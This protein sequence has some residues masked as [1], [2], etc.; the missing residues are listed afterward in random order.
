MQMIVTLFEAL[1]QEDPEIEFA[2]TGYGNSGK[3]PDWITDL[4]IDRHDTETER[5]WMRLYARCHLAM[6]IHGSHMILPCAHAMGAI[7][8]VLPSYWETSI[9]IWEWVNRHSAQQALIRYL[10][11]PVSP[12]LSEIISITFIQLRKL[13]Q[14]A[15]YDYLGRLP[16][17]AQ[18][19]EFHLRHHKIFKGGYWLELKDR[20]G[21]LM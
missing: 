12:S 7:Q 9:D 8:I 15:G 14:M 5:A 13:Q 16:S 6:G 20:D 11:L 4:R 21:R 19:E 3:F 17:V 1:R 2:V 18:R 10:R